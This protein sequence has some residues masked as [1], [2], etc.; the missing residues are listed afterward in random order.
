METCKI[1]QANVNHEKR[2]KGMYLEI[3]YSS[4]R[5][6]KERGMCAALCAFYGAGWRLWVPCYCILAP[7]PYFIFTPGWLLLEQKSEGEFIIVWYSTWGQS[8]LLLLTSSDSDLFAM[9]RQI[10]YRDFIIFTRQSCCCCKL[11]F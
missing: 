7:S 3:N 10:Y 2:T 6:P 9:I 1:I 11:L 4:C 8:L 5:H